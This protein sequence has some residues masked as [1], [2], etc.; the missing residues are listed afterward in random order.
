[1]HGHMVSGGNGL[2]KVS[3]GS[4]MP[5]PSTPCGQP[6]LKGPRGC[7]RGGPPQGEHSAAVLLQQLIRHDVRL[8]RGRER[9]GEKRKRKRKGGGESMGVW[10]GAA[11]DSLTRAYHALPLYVL[12]AATPE[13]TSWPFQ[14]WPPTGQA[15]VSRLDT[16]LDTP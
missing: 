6:P 9:K 7:F 2:L 3:L 4:A 16:S 15:S 14:G 11:M 8:R 1:M 5:Y 12:Q 10:R 13:T